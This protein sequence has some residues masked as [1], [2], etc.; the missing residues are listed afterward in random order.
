K[1]NKENSECPG[2]LCDCGEFY[3]EEPSNSS[4][5]A[6]STVYQ[7]M[8]RNKTRFSGPQIMGFEK[9]A[10]Y[11]KLLEGI[12]FHPYFV[13]LELVHV[14]VFG[15]A[16]SKNNEWGY[17]GVVFKS[18][19]AF[20]LEKQCC[21]FIQEFEEELC[22]V[23][24]IQKT[25][26]EKI[27]YESTPDLVWKKIF[28]QEQGTIIELY[29]NLK[30]LYPTN[31]QLSERELNAWRIMLRNIGC[32]N[33]TFLKQESKTRLNALKQLY[34]LG[35]LLEHPLDFYDSSKNFWNCFQKSLIINKKGVDGK[36]WIL[37]IIADDFK[38]DDLQKQLS[39]SNDLISRARKHCHLYGPGNSSMKK[40]SFTQFENFINDKARV[41]MGSYKTDN[42]TGA[43]V[44]YLHDTKQTL[45]KNFMLNFLMELVEQLYD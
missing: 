11:E 31:Y 14:F 27:Y 19:F 20:Q 34:E 26:I 6:I 30:L 16:K 15:I 8:F 12:L 42:K 21:L 4:T 36:Q 10:I 44:K 24:I 23:T 22:K 17:A 37:S 2:Y 9:P 38:Y 25:K 33:I 40:P 43:P 3:T 35:Y 41:I 1:G 39:V 28:R 32:Q 5:N 29:S 13:D 7:K 45:G 18:S